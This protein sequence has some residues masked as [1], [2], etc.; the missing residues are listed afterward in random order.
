MKFFWSPGSNFSSP[1][2]QCDIWRNL[3][4]KY[5]MR[6]TNIAIWKTTVNLELYQ[7]LVKHF[8]FHLPQE[9][10]LQ[11]QRDIPKT[12]P[13]SKGQLPTS[14]LTLVPVR[15][16]SQFDWLFDNKRLTNYSKSYWLALS[17]NWSTLDRCHGK[18]GQRIEKRIVGILKC[19]VCAPVDGV[20]ALSVCTCGRN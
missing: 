12:Q 6:K 2:I 10:F 19:H 7:C 4:T 5:R 1:K 17:R 18:T 3:D 11:R 20:W 13:G 16:S 14:V 15:S 9:L 8:D